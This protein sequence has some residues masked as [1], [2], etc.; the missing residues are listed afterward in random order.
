MTALSAP[1][2]LDVDTARAILLAAGYAPSDVNGPHQ[3][4]HTLAAMLTHYGTRCAERQRA[5][6]N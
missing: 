3:T 4:P 5:E 2:R 6:G 1:V